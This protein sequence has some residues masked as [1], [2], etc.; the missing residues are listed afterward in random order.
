MEYIMKYVRKVK[1]T[2]KKNKMPND[3]VT[4]V[5]EQALFS[6]AH[7]KMGGWEL[8]TDEEAQQMLNQNDSLMTTWIELKTQ[9][10]KDS[11]DAQ[12]ITKMA[13]EEALKAEFEAFKAWKASQES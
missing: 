3:F 4:E 10:R 11:L 7:E 6:K 13:E 5:V 1:N 8:V 9:E 2:D 12:R